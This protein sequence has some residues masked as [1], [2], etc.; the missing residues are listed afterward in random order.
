MVNAIQADQR[1]LPALGATQQRLACQHY[2]VLDPPAGPIST[3]TCQS[4]GEER[5]FPNHI[6]GRWNN[7][8]K[9][10]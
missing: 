2:W 3:G 1:H 4:C 7:Q 5:D 10:S 8:R 9:K 6:E